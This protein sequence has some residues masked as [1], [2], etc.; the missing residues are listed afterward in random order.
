MGDIKEH[1][2]QTGTPV[3]GIRPAVYSDGPLQTR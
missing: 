2:A 3:T 1:Q